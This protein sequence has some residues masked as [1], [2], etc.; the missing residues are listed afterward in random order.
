MDN[1]QM[2]CQRSQCINII[3]IA[4]SA[5]DNNKGSDCVSEQ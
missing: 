1:S 4:N 3:Y 2:K 5:T